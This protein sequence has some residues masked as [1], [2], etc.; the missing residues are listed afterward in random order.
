MALFGPTFD[1]DTYAWLPF[2]RLH[3][4]ID[5]Q[6]RRYF[7]GIPYAEPPVGKDL[8]F[9]APREWT[10]N[11]K[12]STLNATAFMPICM[13]PGGAWPSMENGMNMSEDCLFLNVVTP[14]ELS[15]SSYPVL[16]YFHAGEFLY[17]AASDLESDFPFF[18]DDIVLVTP[19][20]RLGIFG[21]A[22]SDALRDLSPNNGAV[23]NNG[24]MDQQMA[25]RWVHAHIGA[26]GGDP[27]RVTIMGESSGGTSVIA[28]MTLPSSWP[29]FHQA[30]LQSPGLTQVKP[31]GDAALNNEYV[32]SYLAHANSPGCAF[33]GDGYVNIEAATLYTA[34]LQRVAAPCNSTEVPSCEQRCD[35]NATCFALAIDNRT[36][37]PTITLH[38][39]TNIADM[40]VLGPGPASM[41]SVRM[42]RAVGGA[43]GV[44][45]LLQANASQ[46]VKA[47]FLVPRSDT[48]A[49]DSYGPV[50]DGVTF[51]APFI[52]LVGN[53]QTPPHLP[54]MSAD[55]DCLH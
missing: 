4:K 25:L 44:N 51:S 55:T 18:A 12:Q 7:R 45:C 27:S 8:R 52:E 11:W 20:S 2:G 15:N 41:L 31:F 10:T 28:H 9:R 14:P 40:S 17:G 53:G 22:A 39:D 6:G 3:G 13:Q 36:G 50:V 5:A 30:V 49:Q 37:V 38:A 23:G 54:V 33:A 32:L 48:N 46:L 16:V 43:D 19:A 47:T 1:K 35:A 34:R 24:I 42:K 29:Y 26:F 21:Y